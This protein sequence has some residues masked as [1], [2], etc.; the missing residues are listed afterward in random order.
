MELIFYYKGITVLY[1][2]IY[3]LFQATFSS[4]FSPIFLLLEKVKNDIT[5]LNYDPEDEIWC[6]DHILLKLILVNMLH[7]RYFQ[8]RKKKSIRR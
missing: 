7:K 6:Y 1:K 2:F 4:Q 8:K 5:W 3:S